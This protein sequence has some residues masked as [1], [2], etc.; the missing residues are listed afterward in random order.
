MQ[1][2]A[3]GGDRSRLIRIT[4]VLPN[5]LGDPSARSSSRGPAS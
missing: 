3:D 5:D 4:D 2:F 1:A